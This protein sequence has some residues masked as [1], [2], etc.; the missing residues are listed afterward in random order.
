MLGG[1]LSTARAIGKWGTPSL[2]GTRH[3]ARF[4]VLGKGVTI[5]PSLRHDYSGQYM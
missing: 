4:G 5:K 2:H 3:E 1:S